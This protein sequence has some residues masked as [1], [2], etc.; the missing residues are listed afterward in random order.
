MRLHKWKS[1]L[2]F[3]R[4]MRS[5]INSLLDHV[6]FIDLFYQLSR[7]HTKSQINV[8]ARGVHVISYLTKIQLSTCLSFH[9]DLYLFIDYDQSRTLFRSV[10]F[11]SIKLKH[12]RYWIR[13]IKR[14]NEIWLLETC[15]HGFY[16]NFFFSFIFRID[17]FGGPEQKFRTGWDSPPAN[18]LMLKIIIR[19]RTHVPFWIQEINH[20]VFPHVYSL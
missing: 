9:M 11:L 3:S 18:A 15:S 4:R 7:N 19:A 2:P 10:I 14:Q 12:F 8:S 1:H 6:R 5:L 17:F 20:L 13:N 16:S